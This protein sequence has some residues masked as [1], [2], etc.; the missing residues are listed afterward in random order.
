MDHAV[1]SIEKVREAV[2]RALNLGAM[3]EA[4]E[5]SAAQALGISVEAV[6]EALAI[7]EAA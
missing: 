3:Q 5:R 7:S 1:Y 4:A 2:A 6:R